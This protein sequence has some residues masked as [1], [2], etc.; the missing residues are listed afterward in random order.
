MQSPQALNQECRDRGEQGLRRAADRSRSHVECLDANTPRGVRRQQTSDMLRSRRY[1]CGEWKSPM[2][3]T[4]EAVKSAI[5]REKIQVSQ[6]AVRE[7]AADNLLLDEVLTGAVAG[8]AIE[9]YPTD[10]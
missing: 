3:K 8:E 10:P 5:V 9:D 4:F 6:H 7:L 2:S 1:L